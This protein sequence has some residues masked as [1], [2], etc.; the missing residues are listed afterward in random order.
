MVAR[1]A[2][3]PKVTG[4]SPVPATRKAIDKRRWLFSL[5]VS[6]AR[7]SLQTTK[8]VDFRVSEEGAFLVKLPIEAHFRVK[9]EMNPVLA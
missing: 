3:N 8:K 9:R 2:H 4:S 1:R 6:R 7:S 5:G